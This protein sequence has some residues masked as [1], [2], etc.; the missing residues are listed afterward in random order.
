MPAYGA[1][2]YSYSLRDK[3]YT[4]TLGG[5]SVFFPARGASPADREPFS[6]DIAKDILL[7]PEAWGARVVSSGDSGLS[8]RDSLR[9]VVRRLRR[10]HAC[11]TNQ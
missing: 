8:F 1:L 6:L 9:I 4:L 10:G 11:I 5:R 7:R 3:G 2:R